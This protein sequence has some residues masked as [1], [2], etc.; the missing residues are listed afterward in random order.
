MAAL[1]PSYTSSGT[2]TVTS[3]VAYSY[4][5]DG[6]LLSFGNAT[7]V[8]GYKNQLVQVANGSGTS[9]YAYDYLGQRVKVANG[10]STTYYPETT[11]TVASTTQSKN[12]FAN[13][14]LV[15][16]IDTATSTATHYVL[17]DNLHGTNLV[18]D[19]LGNIAETLD[20]YPYGQAR[21]DMKAG[22]YSGSDRKYIGQVSDP[23]SGL[24]Y[25]NARYYDSARGQFT[26]EDPVFLG[27][28]K[29]Q[30]LNNPQSLNVYSYSE[31]NP[32]TKSDPNGKCIED[33]CVG[34]A[35]LVTATIETEPEWGSVLQ[36]AAVNIAN[37]FEGFVNPATFEARTEQP[38]RGYLE[39][40]YFNGGNRFG[41]WVDWI[42]DPNT[43]K[44]VKII[45][46]ADGAI[47]AFTNCLEKNDSQLT[48]NGDRPN[49]NGGASSGG[50]SSF[51]NPAI[52]SAQ[53]TSGSSSRSTSSGSAGGLTP[54][55]LQSI[56]SQINQIRNAI[57]NIQNAINALP[58]SRK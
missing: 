8:W 25:L 14:I 50:Q 43:W 29:A 52:K 28:P 47:C 44:A 41:E 31:D 26:S 13:G 1:R 40:Y 46:I 15:A 45:G 27:D 39:N 7:N 11:Y 42:K 30:K 54:Q 9:A 21:M 23:A 49:I 34:E 19:T 53:S 10:T 38:I 48:R 51:S 24:D 37:K 4:D 6:N 18:T 3:T 20:Y 36:D 22:S 32:I 17:N 33:L 55:Q 12:I 56:Q 16:T 58:S 5:N 2:S 57:N 35:A